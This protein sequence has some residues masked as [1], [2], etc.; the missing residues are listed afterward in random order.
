MSKAQVERPEG[1]TSTPNSA[2][3]AVPAVNA[4]KT[5]EPSP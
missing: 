1:L 3:A 5:P 4:D 2:T